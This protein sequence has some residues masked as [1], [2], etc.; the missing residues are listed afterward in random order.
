MG[1]KL[2]LAIGAAAVA[3][4]VSL[5]PSGFS[6]AEIETAAGEIRSAYQGKGATS[7]DVQLRKS[8]G[9]AALGFVRFAAGALPEQFHRCRVDREIKDRTARIA[10]RCEP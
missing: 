3:A 9:S 2:F 6:A 8:S 5:W 10:W 1:L 4:A 7:I